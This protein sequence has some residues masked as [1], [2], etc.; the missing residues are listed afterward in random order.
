MN[1]KNKKIALTLVEMVIAVVIIGII[2]CISIPAY[3]A[4]LQQHNQKHV[5]GLK[6][7]YTELSYATN[8]IMA[9]NGGTMKN[10][11]SS[12]NWLGNDN[13][14]NKYCSVLKCAKTCLYTSQPCGNKTFTPSSN[15]K[16]LNGNDSSSFNP[17]WYN[18]FILADGT[19]VVT[20]IHTL[21]CST[22]CGGSCQPYCA[23]IT[24]DV[25]GFK[26]PNI[27]GRDIFGFRV[28]A[29]GLV[30]YG[31]DPADYLSSPDFC[32]LIYGTGKAGM[33]CA[34]KVLKEG[35]MMY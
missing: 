16:M 29:D 2:A 17:D 32:S 20:A 18:G 31:S 8:Q 22:N 6:K 7:A 11:V 13:F 24:V 19:T 9:N 3:F 1:K 14:T 5:E 33:G 30:P 34:A 21:D 28:E 4:S 10:V 26:G 23:T 15:I 35:K 27:F 25:N 12:T